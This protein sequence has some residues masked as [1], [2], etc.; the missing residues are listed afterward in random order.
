[1]SIGVLLTAEHRCRCSSLH[2]IDISPSA[3][4]TFRNPIYMNRKRSLTCFLWHNDIFSQKLYSCQLSRL[5]G[6]QEPAKRIFCATK[7]PCI[8]HLDWSLNL[9][10][11]VTK[12]SASA[13]SAFARS[14][15]IILQLH[16]TGLKSSR[17]NNIAIQ[18]YFS[19][20]RSLYLKCRKAR[21]N[22]QELRSY[23]PPAKE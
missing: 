7:I 11:K 12:Q 2:N 4:G 5:N 1:M 10:W 6:L 13:A 8:A 22:N 15:Y 21:I 9:L 3:R 16:V 14:C 19:I 18:N 20:K 17:D 23:F